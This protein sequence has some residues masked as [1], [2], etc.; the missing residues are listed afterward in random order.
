MICRFHV[1]LPGC[2]S[3]F[4]TKGVNQI[5]IFGCMFVDI[6]QTIPLKQIPIQTQIDIIFVAFRKIL[7]KSI[8]SKLPIPQPT[9]DACAGKALRSCGKKTWLFPQTVLTWMTWNKKKKRRPKNSPRTHSPHLQETQ[10]ANN[11]C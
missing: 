7:H 4:R 2:K 11:C 8:K 3:Q 1:N 9:C 5:D 10:G 6:N